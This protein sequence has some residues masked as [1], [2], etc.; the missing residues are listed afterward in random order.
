ML[1]KHAATD[2]AAAAL[3]RSWIAANCAAERERRLA[4]ARPQMRRPRNHRV[5]SCGG[6]GRLR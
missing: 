6:A 3:A 1:M 5:A 2:A 4:E